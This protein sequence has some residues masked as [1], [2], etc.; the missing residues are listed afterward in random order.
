[1]NYAAEALERQMESLAHL[2]TVIMN[3]GVRQVEEAER[4]QWKT[5]V[6]ALL[7]ATPFF[8]NDRTVEITRTLMTDFDLDKIECSRHVLYNDVG[9]HWF[10]GEQAPFEIEDFRTKRMM[11][12]KAITWYWFGYQGTP[13]LGA[14]AWTQRDIFAETGLPTGPMIPT[15]WTCVNVNTPMSQQIEGSELTFKGYI[16]ERTRYES[17]LLRQWVVA[18]STFLR[19]E[20]FTLEKTVCPRHARKR[21]EKKGITPCDIQVV[22]LRKRPS[23]KEEPKDLL[24]E[25]KEVEWNWQWTVKGHLRQQWYASLGKHLPVYIHPFIKGPDDKPLK[26]RTTPIYTVTR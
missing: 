23:R 11:P 22:A 13:Y 4:V 12:V 16:D 20:F 3:P 6:S 25:T 15:V 5:D 18:A 7:R 19:Q 10:G 14:T 26:P 9:W 8:W 17:I 24:V 1:M 2:D 21:L